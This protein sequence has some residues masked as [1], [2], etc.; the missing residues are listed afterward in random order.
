MSATG[1]QPT[2]EIRQTLLDL[3]NYWRRE[4]LRAT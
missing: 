3:L 2:F 1:W 4:V